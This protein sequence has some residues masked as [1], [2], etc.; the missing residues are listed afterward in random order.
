MRGRGSG[1][2]LSFGL[3]ASICSR[4]VW[5]VFSM[6]ISADSRVEVTVRDTR[7][8]IAQI[9]C[10]G[11]TS[12]DMDEGDVLQIRKKAHTVTLLH[13]NNHSYYQILR[14]KLRWSENLQT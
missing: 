4:M 8:A 2:Q 10:D 9:T 5:S 6:V 12:F 14:A 11:Q 3:S 7:H 1:Y 13:P